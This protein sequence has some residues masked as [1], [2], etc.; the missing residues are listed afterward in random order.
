VFVWLHG[1]VDRGNDN[2]LIKYD[3]PMDT[4]SNR[5]S[6]QLLFQ[7]FMGDFPSR[8]CVFMSVF[9]FIIQDSDWVLVK[10]PIIKLAAIDNGLAF[11]L[12]HPDSWRA[13]KPII[14]HFTNT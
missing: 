11:P 1:S 7:I 12:K 5:V 4:S 8:S 6:N 2:W 10:D 3:Y 13:C 9:V 14:T